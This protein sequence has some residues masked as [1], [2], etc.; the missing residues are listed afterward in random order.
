VKWGAGIVAIGVAIGSAAIVTSCGQR[1]HRVGSVNTEF[2]LIGPDHK[3]VIESYDDPKIRRHH[4]FYQQIA[5]GWD[6]R[7]AWTGGG[8]V[9]RLRCCAPDRS[10]QSEGVLREWRRRLNRTTLG[11]IQAAAWQPVLGCFA[12][13]LCVCRVDRSIHQ[14]LTA[15]LHFAPKVARVLLHRRAPRAGGVSARLPGPNCNGGRN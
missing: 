12:F 10:D 2:K 7:R 1:P 8:H 15:K 13:K 11:P 3:I 14:R 6:Q 4:R 9:R 5:K